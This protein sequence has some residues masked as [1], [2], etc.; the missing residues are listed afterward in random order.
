MLQDRADQKA[1]ADLLSSL[2]ENKELS[3]ASL[4]GEL[5]VSVPVLAQLQASV[6]ETKQRI[7]YRTD[8]LAASQDF[9][10][11]LKA[12]C[13]GSADRADTQAAARVGESNSLHVALQALDASSATQSTTDTTGD[14]NANQALSFVQVSDR[15]QEVTTDDL[16]DLFS[17]DQEAHPEEKPQVEKTEEKATATDDVAVAP[18]LRPRIQTLLAQLRSED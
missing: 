7:S 3:L 12:S 15:N 2:A 13:Q 6:A 17:A 9:V 11:A 14:D 16:S 1:D 10:E 4:Q 5:E 8:S 18:S